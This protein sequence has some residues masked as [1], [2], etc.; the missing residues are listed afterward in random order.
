M[1]SIMLSDGSAAEQIFSALSNFCP[2]RGRTP[3]EIQLADCLGRLIRVS[4]ALTS[5]P[6]GAALL[7]NADEARPP[8]PP[9]D[10]AHLLLTYGCHPKATLTASSITD[11]RLICCLQRTLSWNS[12]PPI[13]PQ[14]FSVPRNGQ[15]VSALLGAICILLLTFGESFFSFENEE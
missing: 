9:L 13:L 10:R 5:F 4:A 8:V 3:G 12:L 7:V 15:P 6:D 2:F 14:E 1:D 11:D